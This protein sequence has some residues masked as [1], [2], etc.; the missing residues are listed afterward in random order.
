MSDGFDEVYLDTRRQLRGVADSLIAA[1]AQWTHRS[2]YA[3][4]HAIKKVLPEAH[5]VLW[6]VTTITQRPTHTSSRG[7]SAP[8]VLERAIRRPVPA[9]PRT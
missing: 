6:P 8:P 7:L 3:G 5:P 1:P 9:R 4:G 2:H